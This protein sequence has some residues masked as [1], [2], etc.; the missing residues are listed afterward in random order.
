MPAAPVLSSAPVDTRTEVLVLGSPHIGGMKGFQPSLVAPVVERLAAYRPDV[1]GVERLSPAS[2]SEIEMRNAAFREAVKDFSSDIIAAGTS[3]RAK[4][5]LTRAESADKADAMGMPATP[6]DRRRLVAYLL[7]AYETPSATLQWSY[8]PESERHAD[9]LLDAALVRSLD[10]MA[11]ETNEDVTVGVVLAKRLG[12]QRIAAVDDQT[13]FDVLLPRWQQF[14]EEWDKSPL[15]DAGKPV[16]EKIDRTIDAGIA[17]G[18]LLSTYAYLNSPE[19]GKAVEDAEWGNYLRMNLPSKLD[20]TRVASWEIRNFNIASN[21]RRA[22][23][24]HPGG[25][26]LVIIGSSHKIILD[27]MLSSSLDVRPGA[28][29]LR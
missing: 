12:L 21:I 19:A 6:A 3:A 28:I 15:R 14:G 27:R 5:H 25:K 16:F 11:A 23:A 9:E 4:T 29:D 8:L 2:V 10:Q 18:N 7:G 13:D 24:T 22:T 20:R 26:M 17:S 1:I